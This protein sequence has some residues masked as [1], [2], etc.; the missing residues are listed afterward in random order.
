MP[1]TALGVS[2]DQPT[3]HLSPSVDMEKE[4][5]QNS[6]AG[7][8]LKRQIQDSSPEVCLMPQPRHRPLAPSLPALLLQAKLCKVLLSLSSRH[9]PTSAGPCSLS[10]F[11]PSPCCYHGLVA[12]PQPW[13]RL[14]AMA[15]SD[16]AVSW[17]LPGLQSQLS[18]KDI[19]AEAGPSPA[20]SPF[21]SELD[22]WLS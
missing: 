3:I 12:P 6:G 9:W 17:L 1:G 10:C 19:Q 16:V 15:T 7:P 22:P 21:A 4:A 11:P 18:N 2:P 5:Q 14:A 8:A 13:A 20:R